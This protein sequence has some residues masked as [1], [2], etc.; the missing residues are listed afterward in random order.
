MRQL[1]LKI[2]PTLATL[3]LAAILGSG[4]AA[5]DWTMHRRRAID[6][7][8]TEQLDVR[9]LPVSFVNAPWRDAI[10]KVSDAIGM[11]IRL[12]PAAEALLNGSNPNVSLS[13]APQRK[14]IV[15][16][17][18]VEMLSGETRMLWY[19]QAADGILLQTLDEPGIRT[20]QG[21]WMGG[22]ILPYPWKSD[23]PD[24]PGRREL[25]EQ[26]AQLVRDTTL[27]GHELGAKTYFGPDMILYV[28]HVSRGHR[29]TARLFRILQEQHSI[30]EWPIQTWWESQP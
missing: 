13:I 7:S 4:V 9:I 2:P 18:L 22:I 28:N 27:F 15:L 19:D 11:P 6:A 24:F 21:Y 1:L 16:R 8:L 29:E 12:S 25:G 10:A 3:L 20:T 5:F 14:A 26:V 17:E 23:D 30:A